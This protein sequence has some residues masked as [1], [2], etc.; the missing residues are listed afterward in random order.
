[1]HVQER[2]VLSALL[3]RRGCEVLEFRCARSMCNFSPREKGSYT[4]MYVS[5][6]NVICIPGHVSTSRAYTP[7]ADC[8][9]NVELQSFVHY[10]TDDVQGLAS[11]GMRNPT[12]ED[13]TQALQRS[14]TRKHPVTHN[15]AISPEIQ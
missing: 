12:A 15:P 5:K 13:V 1:M 9:V 7:I 4:I 3:F 6:F 10:V 14:T 11:N 8:L 2:G